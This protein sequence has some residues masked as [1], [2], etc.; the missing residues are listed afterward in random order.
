MRLSAFAGVAMASM[1]ALA[2]MG[3]EF[4]HSPRAI[5]WAKTEAAQVFVS[6]VF[7]AVILFALAVLCQVKTGEINQMLGI[8]YP[9]TLSDGSRTLF[10]GA[11]MHLQYMG[12]AGIANMASLRYNLAAYEIRGTF[13]KYIC[14]GTCLYTLS[15]HNEGTFSGESAK[16]ALTNS[17]L[18]A[19]TLSELSVI[20][21]Y[22]TLLYITKGLFVVLLPLA[23]VLRSIPFMRQFGGALMAIVIA[24]YVFYPLMIVA[25]AYIVPS[26]ARAFVGSSM[27]QVQVRTASGP[28]SDCQYITPP[29]SE[30]TNPTT[31][32]TSTML[33]CIPAPDGKTEQS[34]GGITVGQQLGL[35]N[36]I[37]S[38]DPGQPLEESIKFN[39]LIFLST[40]F[41]PAFNFIVIAA[42]TRELSRFLGEEAD[43]SR[44]G[45]MI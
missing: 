41:L 7:V 20:F 14:E 18:S 3:G 37:T 34:L 28:A 45:Q 32:A 8:N 11:V 4:F 9:A 1:I 10:E 29:F 43:I 40:V 36:Y 23:I 15:S 16:L 38:L 30:I 39:T 6:L 5:T 19:A 27:A 22:F 2:Y 33:N 13:Q 44:L 42:L 17:L 12:N 35:E 25:D 26:F 21:Q 24:L 31:L